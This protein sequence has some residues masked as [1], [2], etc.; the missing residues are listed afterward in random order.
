MR[1][2][3]AAALVGASDPKTVEVPQPIRS[4]AHNLAEERSFRRLQLPNRWIPPSNP[5][6][7]PFGADADVG[8]Q[9]PRAE[10]TPSSNSGRRRRGGEVLNC[11]HFEG[12]GRA[13]IHDLT[14][15]QRN[16]NI[17]GYAQAVV[18]EIAQLPEVAAVAAAVA[19]AR[20]TLEWRMTLNAFTAVES[21][22]DPSVQGGDDEALFP[23]HVD[24]PA[25]GDVTAILTLGRAGRIQFARPH[26]TT[27]DAPHSDGNRQGESEGGRE[28]DCD[29]TQPTV[30][31]PLTIDL[32]PGS[33]LV[34]S[35]AARW[36]FVHRVVPLP[37]A[38]ADDAVARELLG[39]PKG[40]VRYSLVF[41]CRGRK[42]GHGV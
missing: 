40:A 39:D 31:E 7:P 1:E 9:P 3:I 23:W 12:Y 20:D 32:E 13:D 34:A 27:P 4:E 17:P 22:V 36:D 30:T 15:F 41:G 6:A 28:S 18:L 14:Y 38:P 42:G 8:E 35:G 21:A 19:D 33:L 10:T 25:N 29:G 26:L 2:D 5:H 11:E 24:L 16:R 37:F